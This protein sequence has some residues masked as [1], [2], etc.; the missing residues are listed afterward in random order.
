L[1]VCQ[2]KKK[3]HIPGREECN[4]IRS[5]LELP[6]PKLTKEDRLVILDR[7]AWADGFER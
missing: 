3:K 2:K 1:T 7:L 4:W 6:K 5:K